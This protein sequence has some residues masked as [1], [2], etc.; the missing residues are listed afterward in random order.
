M[1]IDLT[2]DDTDLSLIDL[3]S[4]D[5]PP[6][7]LECDEAPSNLLLKHNSSNRQTDL[8]DPVTKIAESPQKALFDSA[9]VS[10][11]KEYKGDLRKLGRGVDSLGGPGML[12]LMFEEYE[13]LGI[14]AFL[15]AFEQKV[16]TQ[17]GKDLFWR[18]SLCILYCK[19]DF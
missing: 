13:E 2:K 8:L 4:E 1:V 18:S 17:P 16:Y 7:N 6:M 14:E 11:K 9:M 15:G 19:E 10:L 3:I 5:T 12:K